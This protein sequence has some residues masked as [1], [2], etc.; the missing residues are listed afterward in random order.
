[1][2]KFKL[3]I[4]CK[5]YLIELRD[6]EISEEEYYENESGFGQY[7]QGLFLNGKEKRDPSAF[8]FLKWLTHL[9]WLI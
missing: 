6:L 3:K 8:F 4:E 7:L 1:M 9:A 5:F 2:K